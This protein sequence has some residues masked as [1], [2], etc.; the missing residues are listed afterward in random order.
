MGNH[1]WNPKIGSFTIKARKA[2]IAQKF[3][4]PTKMFS[5]VII[6]KDECAIL[7]YIHERFIKRGS[8]AQIVYRVKY[9]LACRRS[10][11]YPHPIISK[12]VGINEASKKI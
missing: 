6:I 4:L 1:K 3:G 7:L 8:L 12:R 10:G 9:S 11:W 5:C 2:K